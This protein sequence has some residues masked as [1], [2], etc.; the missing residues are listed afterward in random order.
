MKTNVYYYYG[1]TKSYWLLLVPLQK[2]Y[3]DNIVNMV[4]HRTSKNIL[5]VPY[6][7]SVNKHSNAKVPFH[8]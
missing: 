1:R 2:Y 3:G 8:C 6:S 4:L 5:M 7:K